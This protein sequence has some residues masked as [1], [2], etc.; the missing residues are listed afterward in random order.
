M[1]AESVWDQAECVIGATC[2]SEVHRAEAG[3]VTPA[4]RW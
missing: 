3:V 2:S 1:Y 4:G